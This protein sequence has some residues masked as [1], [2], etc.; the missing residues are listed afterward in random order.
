MCLHIHICFPHY[1]KVDCFYETF[2]KLKWYKV[3]KQL[4][5]MKE[6]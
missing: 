1:L 5:L 4:P 3:N 2:C 6:F